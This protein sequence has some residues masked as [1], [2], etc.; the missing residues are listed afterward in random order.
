MLEVLTE[1]K[2]SAK[3]CAITTDNASNN[4]TMMAIL[5]RALQPVNAHFSAK[6]HVLCI[7]HVINL[8]MQAGLKALRAVEEVPESMFVD[9]VD[10][11]N[12]YGVVDADDSDTTAI[13]LGDVVR[14]LREVVN[15]IRGSTKQEAKYFGYCIQS[16]MAN[17]RRIPLDCPTRWSSTYRMLRGCLDKRI[18]IDMMMSSA[19]RKTALLDTE[20]DLVEKFVDLLKP[21]QEGTSVAIQSKAPTSNE[22]IVIIK[23]L[24]RHLERIRVGISNSSMIP[25]GQTI[26][27]RQ[28]NALD[29]VCGATREN[30]E[31]YA[32]VL[33]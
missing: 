9:D 12:L 27:S 19:L 15:A 6:R 3:I 22:G 11:T 21:L 25:I 2:L 1:F 20:W 30:L 29:S 24:M 5:E 16:K 33:T 26:S 32:S 31:K 18:V 13:S 23:G 14:R 17:T 28:R 8:V 7:A 4:A 10:I